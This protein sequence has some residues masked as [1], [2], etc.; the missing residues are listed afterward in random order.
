M[1]VF[2]GI[3]VTLDFDNILVSDE[4]QERIMVINY[5]ELFNLVILKD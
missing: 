1:G 2:T 4:T 3:W 5:R